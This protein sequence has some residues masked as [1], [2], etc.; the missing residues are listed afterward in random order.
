MDNK[1]L[2]EE[3][4][5]LWTNILRHYFPTTQFGIEREGGPDPSQSRKSNVIATN[6]PLLNSDSDSDSEADN[7][8]M[9]NVVETSGDR[10]PSEFNQRSIRQSYARPSLIAYQN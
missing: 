6:T 4:D 3:V 2:E 7:D 9:S 8:N 10:L 1:S 5:H